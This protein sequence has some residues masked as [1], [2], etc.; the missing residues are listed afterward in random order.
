MAPDEPEKEVL[1]SQLL[2]L[3]HDSPRS[4]ERVELA[5]GRRTAVAVLQ[6]GSRLRARYPRDESVLDL[7][8][9]LQRAGVQLVRE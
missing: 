7:E 5:S 9:L 1:Y 3:A 2:Q 4:I 6:D 8:S